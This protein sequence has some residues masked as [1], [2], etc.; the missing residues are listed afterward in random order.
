MSL[1]ENTGLVFLLAL[2]AVFAFPQFS[3][4]SQQLLLPLLITAMALSLK[5][6][7]FEAGL[8]RREAR[9][10]G[11]MVFANY[12]V[13]TALYLALGAAFLKGELFYGI[14]L[15]AAA[16]PAVA[17]VTRAFLFGG[18][19]KLSFL[20]AAIAYSVSLILMPV[21]ASAFIGSA[22]NP[23]QIFGYAFLFVAVPFAASR[24]LAFDKPP[25]R[26]LVNLAFAVVIYATMSPNREVFFSNLPLIALLTGISVVRMV[27]PFAAAH[28]YAITNGYSDARRISLYWFASIK[29]N[30]F[31]AFLALSLV[32][33]LAALPAAIDA[34]VDVA[35]T[36]AYDVFRK[37]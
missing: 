25:R 23:M 27:L 16:P 37:K 32:G 34:F 8:L 17:T 21:I 36:I 19:V 35:F 10:I 30:G 14:V 20:A 33:P 9:Y 24:L 7:G 4:A 12:A 22:I 11:I 28:F 6:C 18:D 2:A 29:N 1:L 15:I 31:A 13:L 5:D 26:G 3:Q